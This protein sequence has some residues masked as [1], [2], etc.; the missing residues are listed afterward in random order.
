MA[1][2][3]QFGGR[4]PTAWARK[5]ETKRLR[6]AALALKLGGTV[7][8][9]AIGGPGVPGKMANRFDIRLPSGEVIP[10]K[11]AA[12]RVKAGQ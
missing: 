7:V 6:V 12:R 1:K 10:A 11:E 3:N 5:C 8:A 4:T 9:L 2:H